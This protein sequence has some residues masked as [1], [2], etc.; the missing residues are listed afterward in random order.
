MR[1]AIVLAGAL[2]LGEAVG[3]AAA[4][5]LEIERRAGEPW[6]RLSSGS[7][8]ASTVHELE[9]S[10]DLAEWSR[11]AV[12]HE[13]FRGYPDLDPPAGGA[14]FYRVRERTR[15]AGDDWRNQAWYA[16][17]P[18][19]SPDQGWWRPESR[20]IKFL[21]LLEE[22]QRVVFQDSV[23]YPFHFDF[24][25]A[26]VPG[27]EKVTRE[28]F[29]RLTLRVEG[30]RAVVG[31]LIFP[32]VAAFTELAVQFAGRDA[33]AREAVAGWFETV[34]A[35]VD[36][37]GEVEVFYLPSYEQQEVARREAAWFGARGIRVRSADR[38][39]L[40]DECYAVGW[41]IGRLVWVPAEE[42]EAA[43][44]DGRL[45]A[46]DVLLTDGVPIQVPPVAG[47]LTLSPAT[48]NSHVA[49]L[50][51]SYGIPFAYFAEES[52]RAALESWV[53]REVMV[54]V[55]EDWGGCQAVAAPL[56]EGLEAGLREEI[57]ELKRPPDLA[58]AVKE[59][60]GVYHVDTETLGPA[61]IRHVGGKAANFGLL[62][63]SI[64]E[65]APSPAIAFTFDLWD[66]FL[67][68]GRPGGGTLRQEIAARLAGFAWP[69]DMPALRDALAAIRQTIRREADFSPALRL[70]I[71]G[72]LQE[73]GFATDR[74]IR[75][76]SST[77]V[78]DAEHFSGAGL[79]DSYSGCLGDDLDGDN[80][81]PS[82]CNPEEPEERGVFRAMRRV[83]AS[84]YNDNA[85]L[86]RLRHGVDEETVG[87]GIL[88][89]YSYPDEIERANGVATM[90]IDRRGTRTV[91]GHLVTQKDAV[92]VANPDT[93]ARPEEV[94][95]SRYG[96]WPAMFEVVARSSLVPLGGTVL[97]WQREYERL[98]EL[99]EEAAAA[100]EA[101]FPAKRLLTLD[102]EYKKVDPGRLEVKQIREVPRLDRSAR[103]PAWLLGTPNRLSVFQGEWS[104]VIA[105]HRL[106]SF[107][108][109]EVRHTRLAPETL[110]S[111]L[112]TR[113]AAELQV[114]GEAILFDGPPTAL[115]DYRHLRRTGGTEDGWTLSGPG[116]A[117][118]Y[119][120]RVDTPFERTAGEGPLVRL[121]DLALELWVRY[122]ADQPTL[123]WDPRFTTTREEGVRL[124]PV[125]VPGP[126]SLPQKR[127][128][129]SGSIEVVT[130]FYWPP[131]PT[132][133]VAGY[134]APLE[135]WIGTTIRGLTGEPIALRSAF[136]QTYRPGH[137][138]FT[139]DFVFEP[140]LDPEVPAAT[141]AELEAKNIKAL[142]VTAGFD[143]NPAIVFW[144]F[145]DKFR[146]P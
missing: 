35:A 55:T 21:I 127:T 131:E 23:R 130:E 95:F 67:D 144:G 33:F 98:Y 126:R 51:S 32:P 113:I 56:L 42:I 136:A 7:E 34:R 94:R 65:Q 125:P 3:M 114:G 4:P 91:E 112:F 123:G 92:S 81:G 121:E 44:T 77:N 53:G 48:R 26:R 2:W 89:H 138:N 90:T 54:R 14:R 103:L 1:W 49:I 134:T 29:D 9:V 57:L 13:G 118:H 146:N 111:S 82:R 69:P 105:N 78:E 36:V 133:I 102:F 17:D 25:V 30:Q 96:A 88:A 28:E 72:A 80:T 83:Y 141:L 137:H 63:R 145:D 71:L 50:A 62:R 84:F 119:G 120:L 27:F 64:P 60:R 20:W 142:I 74:R 66:G 76:R 132:G 117:R 6:V 122:E 10:G 107:W 18:F 104:D 24:A 85:F 109:L 38:W 140:R 115:P 143:P 75:F 116:A 39:L 58:L 93:A 97:D 22:P 31:A 16:E 110:D 70:A 52:Q 124:V 46:A 108:E 45:T 106:K 101:V 12:T 15:T 73:A 135:G 129:R 86:E 40:G 59:H 37:P 5:R 99:L 128:V 100:Y 79:Y 11:T 43:Y 8:A 19:R 139:E 47:I 41:T 68:Q 61:D 87:M